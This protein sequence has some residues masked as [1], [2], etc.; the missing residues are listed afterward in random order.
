MQWK[1]QINDVNA[2][3]KQKLDR[4]RAKAEVKECT[5]TPK[6]IANNEGV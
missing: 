2:E 3:K 5:F 4:E 1:R 6:L